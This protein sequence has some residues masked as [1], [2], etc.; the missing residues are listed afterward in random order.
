MIQRNNEIVILLNN[1]NCYAMSQSNAITTG[2]RGKRTVKAKKEKKFE[3]Y[4]Q[5]KPEQLTLFEGLG[6]R[7]GDKKPYS[8]TVDFYDFMPK[9]VWKTPERING[10]FLNPEVRK[11]GWRKGE[12][13]LTIIPARVEQDGVFR[14]YFP[15]KREELVEDALRKIACDGNGIFLDGEAGVRFTLYQLQK[16]LKERGHGYKIAEIKDAL[17]ILAGTQLEISGADKKWVVTSS[18]LQNLGLQTKDDWKGDGKKIKAFARFNP[19]VTKAIKHMEFRLFNYETSMKLRNFIARQLFKRMS[20][21]YTQ[22]HSDKTYHI[23]LSTMIRDFGLKEYERLRDN[24]REVIQ[25]LKELEAK[26]VIQSYSVE[27]REDPNNRNQLIDAKFTIQTH[28]KFDATA[29]Y[30]NIRP[31]GR[32]LIPKGESF[33]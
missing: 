21:Y 29:Y 5:S 33:P 18:I 22:A 3:E 19:I 13:K 7:G 24:L 20:H 1:G 31:D 2:K 12:Y 30:A 10:Q 11:F 15:S 26:E 16:E 28:L 14:D 17:F 25:A 8:N 9:Y 32:A 27:K 6:L 23:L 4:K